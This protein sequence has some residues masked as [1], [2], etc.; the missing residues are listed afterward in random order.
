[1][2]YQTFK[3]AI[4]KMGFKEVDEISFQKDRFDD[5][6]INYWDNFNLKRHFFIK[7]L[8]NP[9]NIELDEETS[10]KMSDIIDSQEETPY[11]DCNLIATDLGNKSKNPDTNINLNDYT[12]LS[13]EEWNKDSCNY[14]TEQDYDFIKINSKLHTRY[15]KKKEVYP[16]VF[17]DDSFKIAVDTLGINIKHNDKEESE[18]YWIGMKSPLMKVI[19]K[20]VFSLPKDVLD[21][22]V[23]EYNGGLK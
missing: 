7:D 16:K 3:T 11:K 9:I 14:S 21:K 4:E 13:E 8:M 1:M 19:L 5:D 18:I 6:N 17:E 12:E 2:N 15:F 23:N 22:Y 10:K 20:A